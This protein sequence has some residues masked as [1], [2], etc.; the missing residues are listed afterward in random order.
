MDGTDPRTDGKWIWPAAVIQQLSWRNTTASVKFAARRRGF[1]YGGRVVDPIFAE[2][3]LAE[4]YDPLDS[5]RSDLDAYAAMVNE[6]GARSVLDIG[7]GTGTFACLLA[8]RGFN[9]TAVDPAAASLEIARSKP[10]AD[11]VR[12]IH[13]YATDLPPHQADLATMTGNVAQVFLTDE[14]WDSTL[15]AIRTA[16]RPGGYLIFE[17]RDPV[18]KAW[19]E[20]T[21]EQSHRYTAIPGVGGVQQ[22]FEVTNVSDH[23]V[24]FRG[25]F[26][27]ESDGARLTS[28]STLRFR[29]AEEVA[30][31]LAAAGYLIDEVREAPDRPGREMVFVARRRGG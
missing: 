3:R 27:F 9:V 30:A 31:S 25:T 21:H 2:R 19:L 29:T 7:C 17:T 12:W 23:V 20:W 4:V 26:V 15:R 8:N 18:A 28:D 1:A 16:L 11:R 22:W 6:F 24:S 5:D 13:G 14:D 10:G